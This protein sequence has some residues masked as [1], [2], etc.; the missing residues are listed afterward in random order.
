M[1]CTASS[2]Q[3][4]GNK[5][6]GVFHWWIPLCSS[7]IRLQK[8]IDSLV[9]W[10]T[11]NKMSFNKTKCRVI[12]INQ[13]A[14]PPLQTTSLVGPKLEYAYVL[15]DPP[16]N[17]HWWTWNNTNQSHMISKEH[18]GDMASPSLGLQTLKER[19]KF[20]RVS[21]LMR[22]LFNEKKLETLSSDYD[23]NFV[24]ADPKKLWKQRQ[25]KMGS[26]SPY[27]HHLQPITTVPF[28]ED[29]ISHWK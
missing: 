24:N 21:L 7:I 10:S 28:L 18:R 16:K 13:G 17:L 5:E 11:K 23:K 6:T 20:H 2:W 22:I 9:S 4:Y 1:D 26:P 15:W 12:V 19:R 27:K 25:L 14:T 8:N 29:L 3:G